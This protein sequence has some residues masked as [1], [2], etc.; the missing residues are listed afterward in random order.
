MCA[1]YLPPTSLFKAVR[2]NELISTCHCGT[3]PAPTGLCR[4]APRRWLGL[5]RRTPDSPKRANLRCIPEL[6]AGGDPNSSSHPSSPAALGA[7]KHLPWR[8]LP[9]L[10]RWLTAP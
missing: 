2:E 3:A 5:Q 7:R 8:L 10:P 9:Y 4:G 6:H 1:Y